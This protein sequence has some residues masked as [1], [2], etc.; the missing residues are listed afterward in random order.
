VTR[1]LNDWPSYRT[2]LQRLHDLH[3]SEPDLKIIPTHCPET[4]ALLK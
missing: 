1:L 2:T 4:A 3:R